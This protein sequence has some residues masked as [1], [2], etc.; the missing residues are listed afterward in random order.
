MHSSDDAVSH[1]LEVLQLSGRGSLLFIA[2]GKVISRHLSLLVD[3]PLANDV[4][5]VVER[6]L[7][8][9]VPLAEVLLEVE[10]L[11][12]LAVHLHE[13][14][15]RLDVIR[16]VAPAET[17]LVVLDAVM[18]VE[19]LLG[20]LEVAPDLL[21][22]GLLNEHFAVLELLT[23]VRVVAHQVLRKEDGGV[24]TLENGLVDSAVG[25]AGAQAVDL[26]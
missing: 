16:Q 17:A 13:A 1:L 2:P 10:V 19:L 24:E 26:T 6:D 8:I 7:V 11:L 22:A 20:V 3:G 23:V 5:E 21:D 9:L 4:V 14:V 18:L 25:T 12:E 15:E